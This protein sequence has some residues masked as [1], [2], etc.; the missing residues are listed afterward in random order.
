[1]NHFEWAECKQG[2]AQ[3]LS[4]VIANAQYGADMGR[5]ERADLL[6][7]FEAVGREGKF[8]SCRHA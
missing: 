5:P 4:T 1:M 8:I 6:A 7:E 3:L 2:T